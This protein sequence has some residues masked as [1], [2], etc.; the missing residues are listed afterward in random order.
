MNA[1]YGKIKYATT[2]YAEGA[3][4]FVLKLLLLIDSR[5]LSPGF[6]DSR[7]ASVSAI[8][9]R[10]IQASFE[11]NRQSTVETEDSRTASVF[12][13]DDRALSV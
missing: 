8:D 12:W 2:R 3:M 11:N 9:D 5:T 1:R 7:T 6:E 10:S 13:V 4:P